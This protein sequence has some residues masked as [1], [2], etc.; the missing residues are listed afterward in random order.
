M[1]EL[2]PRECPGEC[3]QMLKIFHLGKRGFQVKCFCGWEGPRAGTEAE[4]VAAWN[5]RPGEEALR[6]ALGRMYDHCRE[7]AEAWQTGALNSCD[8]R[9]GGRSNRNM[10][11]I[12]AARA[13]L[14]DK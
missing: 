10:D 1:D 9:N 13:L 8:G 12:A 2:K 5:R 14:E 4:A 11:V 6:E 7:S 3:H